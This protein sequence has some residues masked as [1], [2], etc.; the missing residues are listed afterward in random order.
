MKGA[1]TGANE[2]RRG[3]FQAAHGGTLFMDEIKHEPGHAW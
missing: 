2:N 1:F 3:L